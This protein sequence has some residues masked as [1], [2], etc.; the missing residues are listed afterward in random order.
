MT[1]NNKPLIFISND[2]GVWAKGINEL[3]RF[4][5]PIGELVVMA[6]TAPRS[7]HGCALTVAHPV[8]YELVSSEPGVTIYACSGTPVDCVKLGLDSVVLDR[9]PDLVVSGIN[10]GE[11]AGINVHYSGT[12][13]VA[14]EGCLKGISSIGFSLDN[15]ASD[16]D[17]QHLE[18]HVQQI[19]STVLSTKLPER[20]CL[21]VNFPAGEIKGI[22]ICE[23]AIGQ[24][25]KEWEPVQ[26]GKQHTFLLTGEFVNMAPEN[27]NTDSWAIANGY[28]AITP[29]IVDMTNYSF[30]NTLKQIMF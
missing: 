25:T 28:V 16:A 6:P 12:M 2:D 22:K 13:G 19:V 1:Y 4:L 15:H 27:T 26:N 23:Q 10:H 3:I 21:N 8:S 29:T 7:G 9:K 5:Q 17:F 24:W 14:I 11:N 20:T 18:K 30:L